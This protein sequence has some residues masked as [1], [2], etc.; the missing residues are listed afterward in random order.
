VKNGD[1]VVDTEEDGID[2]HGFKTA[3]DEEMPRDWTTRSPRS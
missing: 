1:S 2:V 3:D